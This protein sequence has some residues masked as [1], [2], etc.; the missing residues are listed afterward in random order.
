M[1]VLLFQR[2]IHAVLVVL[3]VLV[4]VFALVR[5]SGDPAILLLGPEASAL[6]IAR[7][8]ESMGWNDALH[9]HFLRYLDG[10]LHGDFG[11]SFRYS[12]PALKLVLERL[13]A[14][15]E[16]TLTAMLL[17]VLISIPLGMFAAY[18]RGSV[19]DSTAML[20]AA[21]GQASPGFWVGLMLILI[22]PVRLG[23]LYTSG[24]GTLAHLILP[25][26]TLAIYPIARLT[27]IVR[28]AT[29]DVMSQDY[30]R[31]ARSKGLRE[32]TVLSR[33]TLRNVLIPVVTVLG[34]EVAVL[35][36][37]AVIT[38]TVFSWPGMGQLA[39][40]AV[41]ARDYPLVQ[42]TVFVTGFIVAMVSFLVDILYGIIDP[43]IRV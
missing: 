1:L 8:R 31:T 43:R 28:T 37:G 9:V 20:A 18:K 24:R 17:T 29:L 25:A 23:V 32:M 6:E 42:A 2:L 13:P 22:F 7:F 21:L 40:A 19:G 14:T 39:I 41:A 12:Q 10:V 35:F 15:A 3:G 27:R 34:L 11:T 36:G 16:L 30:L 4:V 26:I 38:E 33:H 5:L